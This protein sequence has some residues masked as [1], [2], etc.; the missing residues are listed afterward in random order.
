M[1]YRELGRTGWKVSAVSFGAWAIGG[2]WGSVD[3]KESL[4]ALDRAIDLG[5][6]SHST[7]PMCMAMDAASDW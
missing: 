4:A 1:Q 6:N 7:R 5:V 3:D 2:A